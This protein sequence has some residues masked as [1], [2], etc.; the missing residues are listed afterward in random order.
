MRI[1]FD[2]KYKKYDTVL[3]VFK[4]AITAETAWY[5]RGIYLLIFREKG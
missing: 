2:C 1:Y 3:A 5:I 4:T